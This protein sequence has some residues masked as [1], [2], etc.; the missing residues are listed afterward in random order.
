M[1]TAFKHLC[2]NRMLVFGGSDSAYDV[3]EV[4]LERVEWGVAN[5]VEFRAH[6]NGPNS[7]ASNTVLRFGEVNHN[8]CECFFRPGSHRCLLNS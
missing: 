6:L 2:E 7:F 8:F 4:D 1:T 5:L 3:F